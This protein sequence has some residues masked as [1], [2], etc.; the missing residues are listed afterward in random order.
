MQKIVEKVFT[1]GH[2]VE[3]GRPRMIEADAG[4]VA[5][6]QNAALRIKNK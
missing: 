4:I 3:K 5:R 2:D 1:G 6:Q